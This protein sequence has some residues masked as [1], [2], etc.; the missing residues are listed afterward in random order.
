MKI[1]WNSCI[2]VG[3]SIFALYLC[4][5]YWNE[6]VDIISL[7]FSSAFPLLIGCAIAYLVNIL[8]SFYEKHYFTKSRNSMVIKSRRPVCM[9]F[10]FLTLIAIVLIVISLVLPQL[11]SCVQ[12]IFSELP[13][14]I[15]ELIEQVA[16]L[17]VLPENTMETLS[18]EDWDSRMGQIIKLLTSGIGNV[19]DVLLKTIS[20][21]FSGA[22]TALLAIIFSIYLLLGKDKLRKQFNRV[23]G[24]YLKKSWYDMLNYV[25]NILNYN[26]QR[27]IVGQCLEAVIIGILCTIG[28]MIL[29]LPYATM[30]GA[31]IA[32]TALIPV[33][34]A[35][36]GAGVGAFMILMV[37]PVEAVIFL[38]FII[39]L[40]Q[41]EGNLIYPR[42]VGSSLGL[43]GIW[44]L[45]AVTVGGGVMGIVG[46]LLSVPL[47]ATLYCI[48]KDDVYK[49]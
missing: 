24:H 40:Q 11:I 30:I 38:I 34:G 48:V 19:M 10:A 18:E 32:F 4:I 42:V 27:Y 9:T 17:N 13:G 28:M 25:L 23:L 39:I 21:V 47:T 44:V 7:M 43:P 8:M 20:S 35:Y 2:K 16:A 14:F 37:S 49:K 46:M 26:F 31:L 12:L 15:D 29:G 45:A 6:F 22:V 36:I 5:N 41:L 3:V 33:A 1:E